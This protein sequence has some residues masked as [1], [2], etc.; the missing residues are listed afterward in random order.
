MGLF[1]L[2]LLL[3]LIF[4]GAGFALHVLWIV[5]IVFAV[6]WVISLAFTRGRST[7]AR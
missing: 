7:A 4:F 2:I 5:A 1:L 6:V 3:A